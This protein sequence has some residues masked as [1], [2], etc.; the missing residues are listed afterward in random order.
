MRVLRQIMNKHKIFSYAIGPLGVALLSFISL[1]VMTWYY[2]IE[3]IGKISMLQVVASLSVMLFCLGLDQ[4]YVREYYDAQDKKKLFKQAF[5][6]GFVLL[7]LFFIIIYLI[8]GFAI[9]RWLYSEESVYLT[10]VS[11]ACF[12]FSFCS[13]FLSLILRM[14][15]R[16]LAYSVSQFLPK[17]FFLIFILLIAWF[18]FS[19][20]V[21]NLIVAHALSIFTV[22]ILLSWNT[23][24]EW[25]GTIKQSIYI[26]EL[27]PLLYF[28]LPLVLGG[29]A[30]WGLKVVD[31][32]FLR[33]LST[34]SELGIYSVAISVSGVVAIFSGVFNTIWAPLVYKW[35][36]ENTVDYNKIDKIS[37]HLL[38]G[39][40]FIVILSSLF[41]WVVPYMLP[42]EYFSIQFLIPVCV[43]SPLLYTLSEVTSVGIMIKKKTKYSMFISMVALIINIIGNYF[44]IP[45]L[46]ATGAA[47]STAVAFWVF[48]IMRTECARRICHNNLLMQSYI[49]TSVLLVVLII[50]AAFIKDIYI[51]SLLWLT[52]MFLS[53]WVFRASVRFFITK[54]VKFLFD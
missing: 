48:Y 7:L 21:Y 51:Q 54:F 45:P 46:G 53:G 18:S 39:I 11:I 34:F 12:A 23:R 43:L 33:S 9:S 15:E 3:D 32:V 35:V 4:A 8:D 52:F 5:L 25:L 2:S 17:L 50:N 22:F 36:N 38:A 30:A 19:N 37:E 47:I 16:A 10:V 6:P 41:S 1:P 14:Q 20:D 28:G 40:Y 13:R 27:K 44:L 26:E 42:E 31:K 49:K 24:R 29:L